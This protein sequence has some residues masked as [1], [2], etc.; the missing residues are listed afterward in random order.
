MI[1]NFFWRCSVKFLIVFIN[2]SLLINYCEYSYN[3][4]LKLLYILVHTTYMG[5]WCIN[6]R[7]VLA[8]TRPIFIFLKKIYSTLRLSEFYTASL[9]LVVPQ[10]FKSMA[11]YACIRVWLSDCLFSFRLFDVGLKGQVVD[12]LSEVLPSCSNLKYTTNKLFL[13]FIWIN[14]TL[15]VLSQ[16]CSLGWE[17]T[18]FWRELEQTDMWRQQV[19][20]YK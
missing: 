9:I 6:T 17:F 20:I 3:C 19:T 18:E 4:K 1:E 14:F 10:I 16:V 13:Q 15:N 7:R 2:K 8:S 11:A 12:I 5:S